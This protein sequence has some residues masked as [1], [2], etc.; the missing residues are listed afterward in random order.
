MERALLPGETQQELLATTNVRERMRALVRCLTQS[1]E[2]QRARQKIRVEA[3]R[4]ISD[5]QRRIFLEQELRAIR[6]QLGEE[7]NAEREAEELGHRL[8]GARLPADVRRDATRELDRLRHIP[9]ASPERSMVRTYLEWLADLPWQ[10]FTSQPVDLDRAARILDEDHHGLE[11]VKER[12]LEHLA[13]Y[14]LQP[15]LRGPILCFVGPPGVGKTS[16]GKSIA[17]AMGRNFVRLSLGGM[18]DEAEIR[19]HRRT[20]IGAMPGQIIRSMRQ[21]GSSDPVFMLDEVDKVGKD[22]R[23]DPAAALLEV[24]DPEQNATFRDNYLD[25]PF[26]LSEGAVHHHGQ[27]ARSRAAGAPRSD[28]DARAA[29]LHRRGEARHRTPVPDPEEHAW[30]WPRPRGTPGDRGRGGPHAGPQLH[31]RSRCALARAL[32]RRDLSQARARG[33][34][35]GTGRL[36]VTPQRV[37]ELLGVPPYRLETEIAERTRI[38]GVAVAVAW[39]PYGGDVLFVE[40]SRMARDRG[41]SR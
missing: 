9:E 21:A 25:V 37:R 16:L 6:R 26:D 5:A 18:H 12:I 22:F 19:G 7:A 33:G 30:S 35:R 24:L 4:T 11:K 13:V 14:K 15:E 32:H 28:G 23:G 17:R 27:R 38:P 2:E 29:R 40:A 39:T 3:A 20:Y 31:A 36:V 8:D 10:R 1:C 34:G 41:S